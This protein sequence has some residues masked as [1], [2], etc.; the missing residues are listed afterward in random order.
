MHGDISAPLGWRQR[1][2]FLV[3]SKGYIDLQVWYTVKL[4]LIDGLGRSEYI[5]RTK[6]HE[7]PGERVPQRYWLC[8][9]LV[10]LS[11]TVDSGPG[12][13]RLGLMKR[14]LSVSNNIILI[15]QTNRHCAM[16]WRR[17]VV[18]TRDVDCM[19][20]STWQGLWSAYSALGH[21]ATVDAASISFYC[22][23]ADV[24]VILL[25]NRI[26]NTSSEPGRRGNWR[27]YR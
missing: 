11:L 5:S 12:R 6:T 10:F 7:T 27:C 14:D 23:G 19:T 13:T 8:L 26:I 15:D 3:S 20:Y 16:M 25:I 9:L 17:H 2:M 4:G 24:N 22:H 1:A 21:D 18:W